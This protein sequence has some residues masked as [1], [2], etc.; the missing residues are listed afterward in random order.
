MAIYTIEID[1][2][3]YDI[4]GNRPPTEQEAR[5]AIG[6]MS[7]DAKSSN[8][9]NIPQEQSQYSKVDK[10]ISQRQSGINTLRQEVMQPWQPLEHP[11]KTLLRPLVTGLKTVAIPLES[12]E[13]AIAN[14]AIEMQKGNFNISDLLKSASQGITQEKPGQLGDIARNVNVPEPISA[15]L[16]LIASLGIGELSSGNKITKATNQAKDFIVETSQKLSKATESA[17]R[18]KMPNLILD[19]KFVLQQA[20]KASKGLD[21]LYKGISSE[22]DNI[23]N[24]VGNKIVPTS[25]IQSALSALPDNVINKFNSPQYR[26]LFKRYQDGSIV[27]S[28]ENL[29]AMKTVIRQSVPEKVWNGRAIGDMNTAN[30]EQVYGKIND[31][32]ANAAPELKDI[33]KKYKDFMN[34]RKTI[35]KY[36]WDE[37]GNVVGNKLKAIFTENG[38]AG[39]KV[40]FD[41]FAEQWK[42]ANEI[43]KGIKDY[44]SR[45]AAI[46][47][48]GTKV[49]PAAGYATVAGAAGAGA[50]AL[51]SK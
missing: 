42:P 18:R 26:G 37:N 10:K 38:E 20:E 50:G 27:P 31:I 49:A 47:F 11:I 33:N 1:G 43:I 13:S 2:K 22:Y 29:K 17:I 14:P 5:E 34:L 9:I 40:F 25:E 32:M 35:G 23:Y 39:H 24:Q 41:A 16:G 3:Q 7:G 12:A 28:L 44:N 36:I 15:S 45:K 46:K 30:I 19:D 8:D 4:E 51:L 21:D 48:L 6:N